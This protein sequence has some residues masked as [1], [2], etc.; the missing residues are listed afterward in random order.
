[1]QQRGTEIQHGNQSLINSMRLYLIYFLFA[2]IGHLHLIVC[3]RKLTFYGKNSGDCILQ[4][5]HFFDF[6]KK[7]RKEKKKRINAAGISVNL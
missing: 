2:M 7:K 4:N 3:S 6:S 1:M 5:D